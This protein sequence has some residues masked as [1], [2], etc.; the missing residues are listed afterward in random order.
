[1]K[2]YGVSWL[3]EDENPFNILYVP[4]TENDISSVLIRV[5]V[6]YLP[7]NRIL[8]VELFP[9]IRVTTE[10]RPNEFGP[11]DPDSRTLDCWRCTS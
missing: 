2:K 10:G 5:S 11:V 9:K 4:S 7:E 6:S 1:M 3:A 8:G